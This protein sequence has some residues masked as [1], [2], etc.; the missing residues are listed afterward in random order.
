[1]AAEKAPKK[2]PEER[3]ELFVAKAQQQYSEAIHAARN[4]GDTT[5]TEAWL[6]NYKAM[7]QLHRNSIDQQRTTL[8]SLAE[9]F[10]SRDPY[11]EELKE[12]GEVK[13]S[14]TD[15][16][17]RFGAWQSRSVLPYSSTV[18]RCRSIREGIL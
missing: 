14:L 7:M 1:M 12:I 2:T 6:T 10:K 3:A 13:K 17:I 5:Q 16:Q 18:D 9:N 15:E 4:A 11:E 8:A